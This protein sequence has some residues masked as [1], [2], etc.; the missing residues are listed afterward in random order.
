MSYKEFDSPKRTFGDAK[1]M[2]TRFGEG[3]DS[4]IIP[5]PK[6]SERTKDSLNT[7]T[8]T[9]EFNNIDY[10][11]NIT[12]SNVGT[13][14]TLESIEES[15]DIDDLEI[16]IDYHDEEEY[17]QRSILN[18]DLY[19]P[20]LSFT[21]T[22]SSVLYNLASSRKILPLIDI[23]TV[24]KFNTYIKD[25]LIDYR[26]FL[27][28]YS[29]KDMD[30][31]EQRENAKVKRKK[32]KKELGK[33]VTLIPQPIEKFIN[34]NSK[35]NYLK[36]IEN[37]TNIIPVFKWD[38]NANLDD[39]KSFV[40]RLNGEYPE[41][42]LRVSSL[43][44]FFNNI[45][46]IPK[47]YD[48][49]LILDLNTNFDKDKIKN[50]IVDIQELSFLHIIYL[51]AQFDVEDITIPRDDTNDNIINS[52]QPLLVYE[53]IF[54]DTRIQRTIGY[55]DYC[56]FD[57]KTITE[58]PAG[59]RGT[60]RVVLSSLDDS[61]KVLIRR[62]WDDTDITKDKLT[63]KIKLGYGKSMKKLLKDISL[64][65]LDYEHNSKFMDVDICDADISLKDF[66]PD[67]TTPGVIKTLC[68][69][70]NVF[71]IKYNYIED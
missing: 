39:F 67:I 57:K 15:D 27:D 60:A 14:I 59:G 65:E 16:Y 51:G 31:R 24:D 41:I 7:E 49:Y 58:M 28:I 1:V 45:S 25:E 2:I 47:I 13:Y 32:E 40:M 70:H 17:S 66:Y 52:N 3:V 23:E 34:E 10:Q 71:S 68:F 61:K 11:I 33:M 26:H 22:T 48:I 6:E 56:G 37:K 62:G 30:N 35:I 21:N 43:R 8:S 63:G 53:S 4:F 29:M 55:G 50:L 19:V 44:S 18:I 69:R 38:D 36:E 12:S 9:F 42:G 20:T 64:G 46:E 5:A 54:D